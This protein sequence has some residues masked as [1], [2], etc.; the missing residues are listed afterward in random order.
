MSIC[1]QHVN[2]PI[3]SIGKYF[4]ASSSIPGERLLGTAIYIHGDLTYDKIVMNDNVLQISAVRL[5]LPNKTNITLCNLYNQPSENYDLGQL[6]NILNLFQEPILLMGDFNAHHP[7]WDVNITDADR[8]GEEIEKLIL[9]HDYC[10]L[11]EEDS[12]TYFSRTHGSLSSVDLTLCSV[13]LIDHLEW[14]VLNDQYTSDHYPIMISYLHDNHEPYI[15]K[16]NFKKAD[17]EKY[18]ELTKHISPFESNQEHN[19]T[20]SYF[21]NFVLNAAHKSIPM[22]SYNPNIK[23]VS[24]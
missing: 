15:H 16:F 17:W 10:C 4:L 20:N 12:H 22:N 6:A 21:T 13:S 9:N 2:N 8:A 24:W 19:E 7:L 18:N 5:H 11:N 23:P 14:N 1:I 3:P